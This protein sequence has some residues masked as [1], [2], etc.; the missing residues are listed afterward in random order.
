MM[1]G[2]EEL[3]ELGR[4]ESLVS[5][6]HLVG[7]LGT[8]VTQLTPSGKAQ[9]GDTFVDVI[10]DGELIE[11][12]SAICVVEVVGNRLVRVLG[13]RSQRIERDVER[14][15]DVRM[16]IAQVVARGSCDERA[17]R[18]RCRRCCAAGKV[19]FRTDNRCEVMENCN[20]ADWDGG[21][22]PRPP[23]RTGPEFAVWRR[24]LVGA[25]VRVTPARDVR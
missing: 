18:T 2:G 12:G 4:R 10:A 7:K 9:F 23:L 5:W 11:R 14:L 22:M 16:E 3:E 19:I 13:A 6:E 1:A 15:S 21:A 17:R 25:S 20:A 24:A 8:T